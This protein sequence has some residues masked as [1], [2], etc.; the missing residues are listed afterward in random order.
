MI[1]YDKLI[2]IVKRYKIIILLILISIIFYFFISHK[3]NF[4]DISIPKIIHKIY[5]QHDGLIP[6]DL[7][8]NI[9]KAHQSW[10]DKNP[11]YNI[12]YWS[13]NDCKNFL[14]ENY[15]PV[16]LETLNSLKPYAYKCD[17]ARY[18]IVYKYG[19][20]Y[21]DWKEICL[22][23]NLLNKIST[24]NFICFSDTGVKYTNDNNC[25]VNGFFGSNQN[26]SILKDCIHSIIKNVNS[27][28]YGNDAVDPTGPCLFGKEINKY[29]IKK[30][31]E[32]NHKEGN[33]GY[34]YHDILGKIIQHKCNECDASQNWVNGNNYQDMW[35]NKQIY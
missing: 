33:G 9:K 31:G 8:E 10:I 29:D 26:N 14:K 6:A 17:F 24:D 2:K 7:N 5:I 1:K 25:V 22:V 23:D 4:N 20:W 11:E 21:S 15:P 16:Y 12:K 18:C 30:Q 35:K 3:S 13:L 19:G 28:F 27:K 32:F 34:Y